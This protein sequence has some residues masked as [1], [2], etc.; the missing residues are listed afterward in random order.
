MAV[1]GALSACPALAEAPGQPISAAVELRDADCLKHGAL[2]DGI[3]R[4]LRRSTVDARIHVTVTESRK[5][6][7]FILQDG[8][9]AWNTTYPIE[10]A[11]CIERRSGIP[12]GIAMAIEALLLAPP[13]PP[14]VAP[15]PAPPPP[16]APAPAEPPRPPPAALR[17]LGLTVSLALD[18]VVNVVPGVT[19][20]VA[21]SL[22]LRLSEPLELRAA[23]LGTSTADVALGPRA[24]EVGLLAGGL[25]ACFARRTS[26][27]RLRGCA[28]AAVGAVR[29]E[30]SDFSPVAKSGIWAAVGLGVDARW[31]LGERLGLVGSIE[32]YLPVVRPRIEVVGSDQKLLSARSLPSAGA[33]F[34]LGPSVLFW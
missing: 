15:A 3:V 26:G 4:Y 22:D 7:T 17:K 2:V 20:G 14:P 30:G 25:S 9:R 28:G 12:L 34:G 13:P 33:A 31:A 24:A 29:A 18:G 16:V 11:S 23:F 1:A 21:P 19:L 10:R 32:G 27:L 5:G 6:V 8:E